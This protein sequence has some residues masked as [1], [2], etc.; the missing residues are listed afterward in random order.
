MK[1]SEIIGRKAVEDNKQ[2]VAPMD[3]ADTLRKRKAEIESQFAQMQSNEQ[4]PPEED[5]KEYSPEEIE[6]M[7]REIGEQTNQRLQA[8]QPQPQHRMMPQQ[9]Q[10]PVAP[11]VQQ[12]QAYEQPVQAP[13]V[14][15]VLGFKMSFFLDNGQKLPIIFK[16]LSVEHAAEIVKDIDLRIETGKVITLGDFKIPGNKVLYIDTEGR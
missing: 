10:R 13:Q 16:A 7:M 11:T 12:Q 8:Q 15:Q 2:G 4:L 14:P 5:V 3:E 1:I 6:A 9:P